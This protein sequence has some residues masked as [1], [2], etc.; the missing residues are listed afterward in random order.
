M[1]RAAARLFITQPALSRQIHQLEA[2]VG[3]PLFD[4][5]PH[6]V[7]LTDAG[8][9]LLDKA[10]SALEAVDDALTVGRRQEPHGRLTVGLSVAGERDAWFGVLQA[11]LEAYP[12]VEIDVREALTQ[13]LLHQVQHGELDV[14]IG[15]VPHHVGGLTY[16]LLFDTELSVWAHP[17]HPLASR[18][19]LS[20]PDLAGWRVSLAGGPG[21][22]GSGFNAAIEALFATA[23][24][25][26]E[27]VE[28][29]ELHP[30]R[31]IRTA[32]FL[33]VA[34]TL[35]YADG[36]VR[37]PLRPRQTLPFEVFRRADS[38]HAAVREFGPFAARHLSSYRAGMPRA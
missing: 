22:H 5:V 25:P 14:A 1:G 4:R 32:E 34:P 23:G 19:T 6:G 37:L 9:E 28:T 12:R 13:P 35:D 11:Y 30:A 26:A 27:L 33:G 17:R 15:L 10:R 8:R 36:T 24:V 20:L 38:T 21:G 29:G 18:R 16:Q 2:Q 7:E 3:T 31:A